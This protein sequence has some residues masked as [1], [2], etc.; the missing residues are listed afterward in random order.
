MAII[1]ELF[2]ECE[3]PEAGDAM[4]AY[5]AKPS[6]TLRG[7]RRINWQIGRGEPP[8]YLTLWSEQLGRFG[9]DSFQRAVDMSECGID[10]A[11]QL[12]NA[13]DFILARIGLEVDG[14]T[15]LDFLADFREEGVA[16][17]PEG[18]IISTEF[19]EE[20]GN[21]PGLSDFRPGYLWKKYEGESARPVFMDAELYKM[22]KKLPGGWRPNNETHPISENRTNTSSK[23]E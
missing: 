3:S 4:R 13:P 16:W 18:M 10:L 20:L 17:V 5:F 19:W 6:T 23:N 21:P 15:R 11:N 12:L 14:Y 22:W 9:I 7:G 8:I 1:F 2:I